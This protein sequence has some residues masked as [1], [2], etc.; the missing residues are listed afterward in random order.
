MNRLRGALTVIPAAALLIAAGT[1]TAA[2]A[3]DATASGAPPSG[4]TCVSTSGAKAC[5]V[6]YGDLVYVKDTKAN[7]E[8]VAGTIKSKLPAHWGRECFNDRGEAGGW[9]M[10]NFDVPEYQ[11]GEL[12]AVSNPFVGSQA[13]TDIWTSGTI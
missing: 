9:V 12:W 10:C 8:S 11:K 3:A 1:A 7:G 4:A 13:Y 6:A 5:F 2:S